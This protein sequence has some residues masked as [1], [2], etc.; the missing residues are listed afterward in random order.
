MKSIISTQSAACVLRGFG[1]FFHVAQRI[2]HFIERW[3]ITSEVFYILSFIV[4]GMFVVRGIWCEEREKSTKNKL[5]NWN[6]SICLSTIKRRLLSVECTGGV[7]PSKIE[8]R[9]SAMLSKK[10]IGIWDLCRPHICRVLVL[11][12]KSCW[13][14]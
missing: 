6:W 12:T 13:I 10:S 3:R 9:L 1:M 2:S 11:L 7:Y 4:F 14:M 8:A 5:R